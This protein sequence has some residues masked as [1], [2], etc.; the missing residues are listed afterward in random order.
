MQ[1][2]EIFEVF[3]RVRGELQTRTFYQRVDLEE[4]RLLLEGDG[5][6]VFIQNHFL[7]VVEKEFAKI[8]VG[9]KGEKHESKRHSVRN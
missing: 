6:E 4:F 5:I 7:P 9:K 2:V 3:W 8:I 1:G